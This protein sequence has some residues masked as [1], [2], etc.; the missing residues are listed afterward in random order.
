MK[1]NVVLLIMCLSC[2]INVACFA[3]EKPNSNNTTTNSQ[4]TI[5]LPPEVTFIISTLGFG[6]IAG[7]CVGYTMKKFAK[8]MA[9]LVGCAFIAIQVL[10]YKHFVVI[11]WNKIHATVP[12]TGVQ[13]IWMIMMSTL[14]YNFPFAGAFFTGFYLGFRKG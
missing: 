8:M 1:R 3:V 5:P 12:E 6:G 2:F 9:I 13:Q 7:L 10:A 4:S 11:D 14:T